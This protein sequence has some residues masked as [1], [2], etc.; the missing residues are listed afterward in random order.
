MAYDWRIDEYEVTQPTRK[1]IDYRLEVGHAHVPIGVERGFA[2]LDPDRAAGLRACVSVLIPAH[3]ERP[4]A[5]DVGV[6]EYIDA[7]AFLTPRIRGL[8]LE[9]IDTIDRM[10]TERTGARFADAE[11]DQQTAVLRDFETAD[12]AGIFGMIRDLTYEGYYAHPRVL[13]A[14][15]RETAW[16][17]DVAFSG[18]EIE[19]FDEAL[20][21]RMKTVA[22]RY[23]KV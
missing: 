11:R 20:L 7:T 1:Q 10:A 16:R 23:R 9:G 17:Y 6:A 13:R 18:S 4:A 21:A 2:V 3:G 14:L 8:L 15:K 12:R 5:G 19:P 22:P